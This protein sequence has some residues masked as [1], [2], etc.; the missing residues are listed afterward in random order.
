MTIR[1]TVQKWGMVFTIH[2]QMENSIKS[3]PRYDCSHLK[4]YV[5]RQLENKQNRKHY[6]P[7]VGL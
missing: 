3:A 2:L 4:I 1:K 7:V 6:I 5:Q